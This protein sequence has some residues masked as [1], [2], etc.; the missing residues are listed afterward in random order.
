MSG[1][2]D[3]YARL[4]ALRSSLLNDSGLV[5]A[6]NYRSLAEAYDAVPPHGG[7]VLV[8]AG[9]STTLTSPL[10]L[11]KP[12][13]GFQFLGDA[14]INMGV[15]PVVMS[16]GVHGTFIRGSGYRASSYD[17]TDAI[18]VR[19]LFSGPSGTSAFK[20]GADSAPTHHQAIQNI[21]LSLNAAGTV[22]GFNMVRTLWNT[23]DG[24]IVDG[25][26][27]GLDGQVAYLLDGGSDY[28]GYTRLNDCSAASTAVG[29]ETRSQVNHIIYI[30][31]SLGATIDNGTIGIKRGGNGTGLIALGIEVGYCAVGVQFQDN[32]SDDY[33]IIRPEGNTLDFKTLNSA[34]GCRGETIGVATAPTYSNATGAASANVFFRNRDA[35]GTNIFLPNSGY[36]RALNP[37]GDSVDILSLSNSNEVYLGGLN[38]AIAGLNILVNGDSWLDVNGSAMSVKGRFYPGNLSSAKQ[39][40]TAMTAGTG[41]PNNAAGNDG[42]FYFRADGA[43]G[44]LIY[45]KNTGAWAAIA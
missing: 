12:Y 35:G 38:R 41:V 36:L 19:F 33:I 37:S 25:T 11:D 6:S 45:H 32:V 28:C 17:G 10:T 18:G 9:Y 7:V 24:V 44:S 26:G 34:A 43:P 27:G 20:I 31:G 15:N 13:T 2:V 8:P 22:V 30:G 23:L 14:E 16:P 40:A 39:S 1:A 21:A 3:N 4:L 29:L 5:L 42:D